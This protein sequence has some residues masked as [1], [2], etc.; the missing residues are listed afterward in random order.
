MM[1]LV[2]GWEKSTGILKEIE[3][4]KSLGVK[5]VYNLEELK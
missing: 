2:P 3:V 5:I 1:F 4:A